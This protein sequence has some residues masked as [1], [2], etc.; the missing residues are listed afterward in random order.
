MSKITSELEAIR[1]A[2][3]A[4]RVW[5]HRLSKADN[6]LTPAEVIPWLNTLLIGC[7][8]EEAQI[9]AGTDAYSLREQMTAILRLFGTRE[10]DETNH[11]IDFAP[12][13]YDESPLVQMSTRRS[14]LK[15]LSTPKPMT[16]ERAKRI[17]KDA[18]RS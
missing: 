1:L 5:R 12:I 4:K 17:A 7:E 13:N 18:Y 16:A 8:L 10:T 3:K 11:E 14:K 2:N 9:P 15:R 6:V